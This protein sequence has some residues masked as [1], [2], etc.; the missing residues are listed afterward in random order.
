M[1]LMLLYSI[2][3]ILSPGL[4]NAAP[5]FEIKPLNE[6]KAGIITTLVVLVFY[7]F[8]GITNRIS[9]FEIVFGTLFSLVVYEVLRKVH[10]I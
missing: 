9:V 6:I 2:M 4:A 7:F 10:V 8:M 3:L 5:G 1:F